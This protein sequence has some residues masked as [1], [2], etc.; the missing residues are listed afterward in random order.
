M[1][2]EVEPV[3]MKTR[4]PFKIARG[5]K[6][7]CETFIFH[8][9]C[10]GIAGTGEAC[11][12]VFYGESRDTVFE[13]VRRLHSQI[14]GEPQDARGRLL[15]GDLR[16]QLKKDA[17]VRAALDM[18]LWDIEGKIAGKPCYQLLDLDPSMTPLTSFT[19]GFDRPEVIDQKLNE[20]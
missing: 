8:I 11:P 18:A 15:S 7:L 3:S 1:R 13:A 16:M 9:D 5:E 17:S 10:E 12:Q 14:E 20:A 4:H 19:I 6:Q 2:I